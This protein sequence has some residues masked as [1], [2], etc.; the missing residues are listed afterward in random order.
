MGYNAQVR[1]DIKKH[2][3][4]QVSEHLG[5]CIAVQVL[6][7]MPFLLLGAILYLVDFS[8]IV[9]SYVMYRQLLPGGIVRQDRN[10]I[11]LVI[12]ACILIG[13]PLLFGLMRFY[14]R[15]Y[16]GEETNI[17]TLFQPF[18]SGRSFWAGIRMSV[19]LWVRSVLWMIAPTIAFLL[20]FFGALTGI[21]FSGAPLTE[22]AV[23]ILA[24]VFYVLYEIV[25]IPV[26]VKVT[27]YNAGWVLLDENEAQPAWAATKQASGAFRGRLRQMFVFYLSFFWWYVLLAAVMGAGVTITFAAATIL[28]GA[29][30]IAVCA[31]ALAAGGCLTVVID[32]F[33]S[34]YMTTSFFGLYDFFCRAA[35]TGA[36]SADTM[37]S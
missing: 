27:T 28:P 16:R 4:A 17:S 37:P 23:G 15:L 26:Q 14:I 24:A 21:Y 18:A 33:L 5:R 9:T 6:Y 34:A 10:A 36:E 30:G 35:Q 19:V 8:S 13:G 1:R 22:N 29:K 11:C 32:S 31:L 2:C 25:C 12:A 20:I 7:A 3:R